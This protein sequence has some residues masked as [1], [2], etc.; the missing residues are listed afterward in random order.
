MKTILATAAL[1]LFAASPAFA[2]TRL[3]TP[4]P[5]SNAPMIRIPPSSLPGTGVSE[6]NTSSPEATYPKPI[7]QDYDPLFN[8]PTQRNPS[9][10]KR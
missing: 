10:R 9:L 2:Q 5:N 3:R 6:L 7:K 4:T 1:A 8:D